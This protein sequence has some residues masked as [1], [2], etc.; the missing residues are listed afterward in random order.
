MD[1]S[2]GAPGK[3]PVNPTVPKGQEI[4]EGST[5]DLGSLYYNY[6]FF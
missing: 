5:Q 3:R 4:Q 1:I 6:Y 2:G